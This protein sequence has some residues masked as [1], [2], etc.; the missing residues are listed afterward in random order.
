M[1]KR[2]ICRKTTASLPSSAS[3]RF[4][5]LLNLPLLLRLHEGHVLDKNKFS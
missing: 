5:L 3:N 2:P 4:P 1:L